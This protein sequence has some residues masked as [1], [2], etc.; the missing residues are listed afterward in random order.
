[1]QFFNSKMESMNI[2]KIYKLQVRINLSDTNLKNFKIRKVFI[3][4]TIGLL[5]YEQIQIFKGL[6]ERIFMRKQKKKKRKNNLDIRNYPFLF[7]FL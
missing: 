5:I 6:D 2:R 4:Y 1:M 7:G 3:Y